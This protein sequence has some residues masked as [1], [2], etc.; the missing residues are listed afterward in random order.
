MENCKQG[1]GESAL[2][3]YGMLPRWLCETELRMTRSSKFVAAVFVVFGDCSIAVVAQVTDQK[4][5]NNMASL[6][7]AEAVSVHQ[8]SKKAKPPI[9][10]NASPKVTMYSFE[11]L[12]GHGLRD[13]VPALH[14]APP[15]APEAQTSA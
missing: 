10:I 1:K 5:A 7:E 13:Q 4:L 6:T 11:P 2:N 8:T 3:A 12:E 15:T 9:H 14:D